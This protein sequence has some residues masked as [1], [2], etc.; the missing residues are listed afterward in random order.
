MALGTLL[1]SRQPLP[2]ASLTKALLVSLLPLSRL[3]LRLVSEERNIKVPQNPTL[4]PRSSLYTRSRLHL[5]HLPV[6]GTI[7]HP[8][9]GIPQASLLE[10]SQ[11]PQNQASKTAFIF[12]VLLYDPGK[13]V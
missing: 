6:S 12:H 5:S 13:V 10:V 11:A 2:L 4:G 3:L 8:R 9:P 1:S 7:C